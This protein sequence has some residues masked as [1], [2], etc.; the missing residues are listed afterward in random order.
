MIEHAEDSAA[1]QA[2]FNQIMTGDLSSVPRSGS[3]PDWQQ[4]LVDHVFTHPPTLDVL[5][6]HAASKE[7]VHELIGKLCVAGC[8]QMV[9]SGH[10]VMISTI[11]FHHSLDYALA[12]AHADGPEFMGHVLRLIDYYEKDKIGPIA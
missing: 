5:N 12:H 9:A 4:A 3:T 1:N 2:R 8:D 10:N 11:F 6:E 7:E